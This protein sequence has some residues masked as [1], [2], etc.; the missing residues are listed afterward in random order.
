MESFALMRT[1]AS[2]PAAMDYYYRALDL[3]LDWATAMWESGDEDLAIQFF[4]QV[5]KHCPERGE[6]EEHLF[7]IS[8]GSVMQQS[9]LC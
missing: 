2:P 6:V 5:F 8:W 3:V 7:T 4:G 9:T 1:T